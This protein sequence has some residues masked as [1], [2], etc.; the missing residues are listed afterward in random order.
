MK[1]YQL[2][3][4]N[5]IAELVEYIKTKD[6]HGVSLLTVMDALVPTHFSSEELRERGAIVAFEQLF[7][8]SDKYL[9]NIENASVE[10]QDYLKRLQLGINELIKSWK[11][12]SLQN[13][14]LEVLL[15]TEALQSLE[16][17]ENQGSLDIN[18]Q[19][20]YNQQLQEKFE[21]IYDMWTQQAVAAADNDAIDE[22]VIN[23]L[24]AQWKNRTGVN[25]QIIL[26]LKQYMVDILLARYQQGDLSEVVFKH[27]NRHVTEMIIDSI[28]NRTIREHTALSEALS[29][30]V[31]RLIGNELVTDLTSYY[32]NAIGKLLEKWLTGRLTEEEGRSLGNFVKN[33]LTN[34]ELQGHERDEVERAMVKMLIAEYKAQ[35]LANSLQAELDYCLS[36]LVLSYLNVRFQSDEQFRTSSKREVVQIILDHWKHNVLTGDIPSVLDKLLLQEV[37]EIIQSISQAISVPKN[38]TQ[39][40]LLEK[41]MQGLKED[42]KKLSDLEFQIQELKQLVNGL[43]QLNMHMKKEN[44]NLKTEVELLEAYKAQAEKKKI[45]PQPLPVK[46][47]FSPAPKDDQ[48]DQDNNKAPL[49][50]P[51]N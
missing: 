21:T 51:K 29:R 48:D 19:K 11:Q 36:N 50:T 32:K 33:S 46:T 41:Q 5:K 12:G 45:I 35:S 8:D 10:I 23:N 30:E 37:N 44:T 40:R 1:I 43:V 28:E 4:T 15:T 2:M 16:T 34:I 49:P 22:V 9:V 20:Y 27:A 13:Q 42:L 31:K 25:P 24:L 17:A 14:A 26:Q 7:T 39:L 6:I 38:A 47:F 18:V 3:H